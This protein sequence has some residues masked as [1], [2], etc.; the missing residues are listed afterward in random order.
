M[1]VDPQQALLNNIFF[2]LKKTGMSRD[3]L[4]KRIQEFESGDE[5][6]GFPEAVVSDS[7]AF[8]AREFKQREPLMTVTTTGQVVLHH[9]SLG[10][11]HAWRGVGKS[12]WTVSWL[13]MLA[14]GGRF[15]AYGC[16][17]DE[18]FK[19]LYVDGELT[20]EDLQE[21]LELAGGKHPNLKI[22]TEEEQPEGIP[23][24]AYP[25]GQAWFEEAI[26]KHGIEVAAFD[27]WSTLGRVPTNDE[28]AFLSFQ[29]WTK[30]MRLK[31]V[32]ILLTQH[33]GKN[34]TQRGHSRMDDLLNWNIQLKWPK[35]YTGGDGLKA[36]MRFDKARKPVKGFSELDIELVLQPDG[37]TKFDWGFPSG[38]KEPENKGGRPAKEFTE[39]EERTIK[40]LYEKHKSWRK[41]AEEM[42][43]PRSRIERWKDK[44]RARPE[45]KQQGMY[46]GPNQGQDQGAAAA[47]T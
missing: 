22:I 16:G 38:E 39:A 15:L 8:M 9:P 19:V 2:S 26:F 18:G 23:S 4:V 28:E 20:G 5:K 1:P 47:D 27:S 33:D 44:Q 3:E 36:T 17:K 7:V 24:V 46:D 45:P 21:M 14:T 37:S 6:K 10:G 34:G 41:V 30:K 40:E 29:T 31:G 11:L 43:V 35:G 42:G 12:N 32:T 13:L 25:E